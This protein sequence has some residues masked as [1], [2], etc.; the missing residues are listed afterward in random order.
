MKPRQNT[1]NLDA[2]IDLMIVSLLPSY[3]DTFTG[4]FLTDING[5]FLDKVL[6][7]HELQSYYITVFIKNNDNDKVTKKLMHSH[8]NDIFNEII[9]V[10]PKIILLLGK[11]LI[12]Y[13]YEN[14]ES[15]SKQI[16]IIKSVNLFNPKVIGKRTKAALQIKYNDT[17]YPFIGCHDL[18]DITNDG[19]LEKNKK[20]ATLRDCLFNIKDY[21]NNL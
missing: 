15:I 5:V 21:L 7:K 12:N 11:N 18:N 14:N 19:I 1:N 13:F 6:N 9:E 2:S 10:N 17:Y 8:Y 16:N 3:C 20:K 4:Y